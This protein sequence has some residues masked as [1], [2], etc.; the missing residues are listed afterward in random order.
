[1]GK[2]PIDSPAYEVVIKNFPEAE[3]IMLSIILVKIS[4]IQKN[5]EKPELQTSATLLVKRLW[6]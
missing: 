6:H 2:V 5:R 3:T 1:M 4:E